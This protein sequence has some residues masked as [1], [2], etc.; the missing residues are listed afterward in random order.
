MHFIIQDDCDRIIG[1]L[2]PDID[3]LRGQN[4]LVTGFSGFVGTYISS[5]IAF[6][7]D[8]VLKRDPCRLIGLDNFARGRAD[9]V[10]EIA[11]STFVKVVDYDISQGLPDTL[12]G[13]KV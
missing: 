9:W 1:E 3:K 5:L 12:E 6:A 11:E 8:T 4:I 10:N 7:N 2:S 13:L